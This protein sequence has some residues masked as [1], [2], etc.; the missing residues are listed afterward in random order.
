VLADDDVAIRGGVAISRDGRTVV[1]ADT[2]AYRVGA[3]SGLRPP[4]GR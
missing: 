4:G 1:W 3:V 2:F